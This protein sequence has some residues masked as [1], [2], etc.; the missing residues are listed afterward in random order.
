[1]V[2]PAEYHKQFTLPAVMFVIFCGGIWHLSSIIEVLNEL[3]DEMYSAREDFLHM[4]HNL[5]K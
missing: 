4:T 2:G 5:Y 3:K 1:V